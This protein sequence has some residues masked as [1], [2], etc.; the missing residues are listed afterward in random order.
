MN[1]APELQA[2][3]LQVAGVPRFGA[4][5]MATVLT[6]DNPLD[7]N[8]FEQPTKIVPHTTPVQASSTMA[9]T[10]PANSL[11]IFRISTR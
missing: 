7:E 6:S 4:R 5:A 10:F 1:A 9:H 11:T 3:T 2:M 8:T